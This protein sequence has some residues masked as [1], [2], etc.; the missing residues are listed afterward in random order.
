MIA[1]SG[2]RS[3]CDIVARNWLL[4]LLACSASALRAASSTFALASALDRDDSRTSKNT[5]T[6]AAMPNPPSS[7]NESA[8]SYPLDAYSALVGTV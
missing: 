5:Q 3:S 4:A 1:L 7:R 2:V 8:G 6:S